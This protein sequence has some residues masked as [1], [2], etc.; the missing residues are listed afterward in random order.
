MEHYIYI[1]LGM[2]VFTKINAEFSM[3]TLRI[4]LI[5][6]TTLFSE[7]YFFFFKQQEAL[8]MSLLLSFE[9]ACTVDM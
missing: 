5:N 8:C 9:S 6:T 1:G 4:L 7:T 3:G 2:L